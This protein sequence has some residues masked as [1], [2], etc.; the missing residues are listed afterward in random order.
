MS[1]RK[2]K[3]VISQKW[4]HLVFLNFQAEPE[5]IQSLLPEGFQLD[6]FD[7]SGY[8]SI[9]PFRMSKVRFPFVPYLPFTNLWELN[10]RTYVVVN[11]VK[12]IY[13][14]TL[15]TNHWFAAW[16]AKKFFSLPYRKVSL[17]G[18]VAGSFISYVSEDYEL[19]GTI[20]SEIDKSDFHTWICER[21]RLFTTKGDEI[22]Q[23]TAIHKPWKL[24]DF[25]I[26]V[27]RENFLEVFSLKPS[28]F[29][30]AFAGG[31]LEVRFHPFRIT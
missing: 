13:F 31:D 30:S 17:K 27:Q 23:G 28:Q 21:Y 16:I 24:Y 3:W 14:F 18:N 25:N 4:Q 26:D 29:H 20:G 5:I 11:G 7:G 8:L 10:I 2:D 15:D 9:V 6:T 1:K 22:Y 12:G 19:S